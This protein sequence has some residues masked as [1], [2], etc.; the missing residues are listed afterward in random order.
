MVVKWSLSLDSL[1]MF[2]K[3]HR[4]FHKIISFGMLLFFTLINNGHWTN[5]LTITFT[6]EV[7]V[8]RCSTK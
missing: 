3:I 7:A 1:K 4:Q 6:L 5:N 2:K 8:G